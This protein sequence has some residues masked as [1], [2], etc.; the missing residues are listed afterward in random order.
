MLPGECESCGRAVRYEPTV[1]HWLEGDRVHRCRG[2]RI[3]ACPRC[4]ERLPRTA[5]YWYAGP[6]RDG[7]DSWCKCCRKDANA[8]AYRARMAAGVAG[9]RVNPLVPDPVP[10]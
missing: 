1:R 5:E 10:A 8:E 7:F 9:A 3:R 4:R 2:P 6:C